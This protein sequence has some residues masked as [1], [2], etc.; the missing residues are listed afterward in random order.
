MCLFCVF[1]EMFGSFAHYFPFLIIFIGVQLV[2]MLVSGIQQSESVIG[3]FFLL[4]SFESSSY[5]WI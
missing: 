2:T 1:G 4:L 3:L 5:F